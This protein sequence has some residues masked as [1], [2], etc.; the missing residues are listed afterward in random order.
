MI[1]YFG[2]L[3][4]I[5]NTLLDKSIYRGEAMDQ[6]TQFNLLGLLIAAAIAIVPITV[7]IGWEI[8][9]KKHKVSEEGDESMG[10][11]TSTAD[12]G[13]TAARDIVTGGRAFFNSEVHYHD[14]INQR[15][16]EG[17]SEVIGDL[18]EIKLAPV[19]SSLF[20]ED[21]QLKT[22]RITISNQDHGKIEGN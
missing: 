6:T 5:W 16:T 18:A 21:N 9:Q 13:S 3:Y 1:G 10:N 4:K 14:A 12:H 7:A 8:Y 2:H 20:A 15:P 19:Y 11:N 17:E 22:E